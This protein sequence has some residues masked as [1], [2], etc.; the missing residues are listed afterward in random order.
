MRFAATPFWPSELQ[1]TYFTN[2]SLYWQTFDRMIAD[3]GVI[4]CR[5]MPSI[6]WQPYAWI[7]TFN[8][9]GGQVFDVDRESPAREAMI[10]YTTKIVHRYAASPVIVAWELG[11]EY[12]LIVDLSMASQSQFCIAPSKGTPL[13]RTDADNFTTSQ[14]MVFQQLLVTTIRQSDPLA[15]PI[16]SGNAI[17]RPFATALRATYYHPIPLGKLP[18]DTIEQFINITR[19]QNKHVDWHSA[20]IYAGTDN[21]R[22]KITDPLSAELLNYCQAAALQDGKMLYVGEFGDPSP[23]NR[24]FTRNVLAA[25]TEAKILLGTVW[26]WAFFQVNTTSPADFSVIPGRDDAIITTLQAWNKEHAVVP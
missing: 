17:A 8:E 16:S 6:F 7:D 18:L 2:E 10:D 23:G 3:V 21:C 25:M 12:N 15:R 20:H 11:N 4:G 13:A 5:V 26:I 14:Y 22:W 9:T 1:A 19:D 24:T